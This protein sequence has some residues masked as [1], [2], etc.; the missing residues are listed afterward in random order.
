[1]QHDPCQVVIADF[2]NS[3]NDPA[4]TDTGTDAQAGARRREFITAY[5]PRL[6]EAQ[7][8][9]RPPERL[10]EAAARRRG[11]ASRPLG[12]CWPAHSE[13]QGQSYRVSVRATQAVTGDEITSE[14]AV[15]AGKDQVLE[16]ATRLM[17][18]VRTHSAMK[19]RSLAQMFAMMTM[20]TTSLDVVRLYAD[21]MSA[22]ST[23]KFE[24]ARQALLK[25]I[26]PSTRS[27]DSRTR[28]WR[29]C[30]AI[31]AACRT[32]TSTST[33]PFVTLTG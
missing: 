9:I 28:V 5:R 15:A 14:Q 13:P 32:P 26:E 10:D 3:T 18:R 6:H 24:E 16:T 1:M 22:S 2:V 12:W 23:G 21:A 31:S 8:G 27:S 17:A 11:C 25:A 4:L 19:S 33:R 20:T 29:E 30:L 7:L